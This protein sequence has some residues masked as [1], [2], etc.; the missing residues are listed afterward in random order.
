MP[1]PDGTTLSQLEDLFQNIKREIM[2]INKDSAQKYDP[3][4]LNAIR[5][6]KGRVMVKWTDEDN[7][8]GWKPGWYAAIVKNYI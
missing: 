7:K 1:V 2:L 5:S 8:Q 4:N 3:Y 6:N